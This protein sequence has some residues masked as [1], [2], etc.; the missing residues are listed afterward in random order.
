MPGAAFV[1]RRA[2]SADAG[3]VARLVARLLTELG[4][5]R[6]EYRPERLTPEV[7]DMLASDDRFVAILAFDADVLA[8]GPDWWRKPQPEDRRKRAKKNTN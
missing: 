1:L 2:T 4:G 7:A 6:A 3:V 8:D 5:A